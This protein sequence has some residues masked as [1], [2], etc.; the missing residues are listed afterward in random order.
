MNDETRVFLI[1]TEVAAQ[2]TAS[3]RDIVPLYHP[4]EPNMMLVGAC[5]ALN[6]ISQLFGASEGV[7]FIELR[8]TRIAMLRHDG[9]LLF[10]VAARA[11]FTSERRLGALLRELRDLAL[12]Y[13][14][15]L[16]NVNIAD[17]VAV[18]REFDADALREFGP[19][20]ASLRRVRDIP[21]RVFVQATQLLRQLDGSVAFD[22]AAVVT[23]SGGVLA[24]LGLGDELV[25]HVRARVLATVGS[26]SSLPTL[27][28]LR[29][30]PGGGAEARGL[31][32]QSFQR[33]TLAVLMPLA[34]LNDKNLMRSTSILTSD[35]LYGIE[36][37]LAKLEREKERVVAESA[38]A[39]NTP[40]PPASLDVEKAPVSATVPTMA[41]ESTAG[42]SGT[43]PAAAGGVPLDSEQ[44]A[45]AR[46]VIEYNRLSHA[47]TYNRPSTQFV[48]NTTANHA[49]FESDAAVS[50]IVERKYYA[51][52][53][54][55][56]EFE[57]E[58][59]FQSNVGFNLNQETFLTRID[60]VFSRLKT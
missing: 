36:K 12:F 42:T 18:V 7:E 37:R 57:T 9:K 41:S 14:G 46:A 45:S 33:V 43:S 29:V 1:D 55:K 8:D 48:L 6:D 21:N 20:A 34:L 17:L 11:A 25:R 15:A 52:V 10:G 32:V 24:E 16:P 23:A 27:Q 58:T 31:F 2:E 26:P 28:F 56:R 4:G 35:A 50:A 38:T 39:A 44:R 30:W 3:V 47:L 5:Q 54:S 60:D 22:G 13:A 19:E 59:H 51:A 49:L 40:S 53:Y